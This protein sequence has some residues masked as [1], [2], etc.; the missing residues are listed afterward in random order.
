[1]ESAVYSQAKRISNGDRDLEQNVLAWNYVNNVNSSIRGKALSI[2]EQVNFI[3]YRA[4]EFKSGRRRDFG[5]T[6]YKA[7]CDVMNKQLYYNNEVSILHL[8]HQDGDNDENP[9]AGRGDLTSLT[10][11]KNLE[12]VVLFDID[13]NV[14]L[15][16]LKPKERKVF[17]D[18]LSGHTI[19]EIA[20]NS[21]LCVSTVKKWIRN[22]GQAFILYFEIG[23]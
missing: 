23:Y 8:D 20:L 9:M 15:M 7:T 17:L 19:K 2:G 22:I 5:H 1:M 12:D 10:A 3:K 13:F 18:R 11:I 14:F 4:G 21:G 16:L 6:G